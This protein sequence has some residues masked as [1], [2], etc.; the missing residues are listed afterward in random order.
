MIPFSSVRAPLERAVRELARSLDKK[1]TFELSGGEVKLDRALLDALM[2]PLNHLIRNA[3]DHGV[4]PSRERLAGGKPEAGLVKIHL[5]RSSDTVVLTLEDD[6]SG[7]DPAG[8]R[9]RA[10]E[11]GHLTE[12]AA[13]SLSDEEVLRLAAL[14]GLSTQSRATEVSGRGVGL[15][16]VQDRIARLG[17]EMEISSVPGSGTRVVLRLPPT[18]AVV[19]AFIVRGGGETYAVPVR[20]VGRILGVRPEK[21][22][23]EGD[24]T[25]LLTASGGVELFDLDATLNRKEHTVPREGVA[26]LHR[27]KGRRR[28]AVVEAVLER[29]DLVVKPLLD[30]LERMREY[31]GAARLSDG[32]VVLLVDLENVRAPRASGSARSAA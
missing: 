23:K 10:V 16:A 11:L 22:T 30:P 27:A 1:V 18:L 19:P 17:G 14:P 20:K 9:E 8:L 25:V 3:V 12:E 15:D 7:L 5:E 24:A 26:L 31:T 6:G 21:V 4:E 32:Q 2:D 13:E 28:A 29:C